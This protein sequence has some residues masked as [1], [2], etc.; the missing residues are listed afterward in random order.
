MV[1]SIFLPL[2]HYC[3]WIKKLHH[4]ERERVRDMIIGS[5]ALF[6]KMLCFFGTVEF[7]V[8]YVLNMLIKFHSTWMLFTI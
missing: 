3:R 7:H 2:V 8:L 4:M 6:T 1:L 5:V